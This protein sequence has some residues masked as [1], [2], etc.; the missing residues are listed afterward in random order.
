MEK[1]CIFF[2]VKMLYFVHFFGLHLA[3]DFKM[4]KGFGTRLDLELV[5]KVQDGIW[6]IKCESPLISVE[7]L[8]WF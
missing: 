8:K 1:N 5:L 3:F 4:K 7:G 6:I 2:V